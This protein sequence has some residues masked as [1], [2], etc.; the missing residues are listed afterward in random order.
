MFCH[1]ILFL[2]LTS[3]VISCIDT[4]T[5]GEKEEADSTTTAIEQ[6]DTVAITN[7]PETMDPYVIGGDALKKISDTL[8]V[9]MYLFTLKPG[10]SAALHSHPDHLVYILEGGKAEISF[11]GQG[12]QVM[13][14]KTGDGFVTGPISDAGKNIGTTTIKMLVADIHRPR[15]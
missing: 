11:Q 15:N 5:R 14:F 7:I 1:G 12:T 8:G 13:E 9:K 10:D 3:T 4:S 2:L 6:R